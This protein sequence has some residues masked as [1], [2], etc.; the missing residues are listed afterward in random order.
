MILTQGEKMVW[1]AAFVSD[2]RERVRRNGLSG[3]GPLVVILPVETAHAS[4]IALRA[5]QD[6]LK[7]DGSEAAQMLRAML[8]DEG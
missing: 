1:A 7:D 6:Q 5:A 8:G 4:I 2:F 3:Q